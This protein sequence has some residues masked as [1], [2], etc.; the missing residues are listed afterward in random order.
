MNLRN[1]CTHKLPNGKSAFKPTPDGLRCSVCGGILPKDDNIDEDRIADR[2]IDMWQ[3]IRALYGEVPDMSF[4]KPVTARHGPRRYYWYYQDS[5]LD[6][7]SAIRA[8]DN[9]DSIDDHE[10]DIRVDKVLLGYCHRIKVIVSGL[11]FADMPRISHKFELVD[12]NACPY[13]LDGICE[14]CDNFVCAEVP[15]SLFS[16]EE[17][18]GYCIRKKEEMTNNDD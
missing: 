8:I 17:Y 18:S 1:W 11:N 6:I 13:G 14:D 16:D 15:K 3:T 10:K 12:T 9:D 7:Y 4:P 2:A 5:N